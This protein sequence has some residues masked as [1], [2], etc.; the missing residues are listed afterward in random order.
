MNYSSA[1]R[2]PLGPT[3]NEVDTLGLSTPVPNAK[4]GP[5]LRHKSSL[6]ALNVHLDSSEDY[7]SPHSSIYN[8]SVVQHSIDKT[9]SWEECH[10]LMPTEGQH[11]PP[12]WENIVVDE[13]GVGVPVSFLQPPTT[14]KTHTPHELYPITEQSSFATLRPSGSFITRGRMSN[15]TL[16][17]R[18]PGLNGK[19]RKSFSL[20][21]LPPAFER[22]QSSQD[23]LPL[24]PLPRPVQP[25]QVP[26]ERIPTPPGLP[27][28]NKP[29]AINY[30]LPPPKFRWRHAFAVPSDAEMEWRRQTVGLPRGVVMRGSNG[31]LVRGK[32]TPIRSA[33]FPPLHQQRGALFHTPGPYAAEPAQQDQGVIPP[34][35]APT[36]HF[37]AGLRT[38]IGLR[39]HH[40][41]R[42]IET[43]KV[44]SKRKV[45][46]FFCCIRDEAAEPI[47][48]SQEDGR[49]GGR[50]DPRETPLF[51]G[52][53]R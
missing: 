43:K 18:S 44:K 12:P 47:L 9:G 38:R 36:E 51:V 21:D 40:R 3:T 50:A 26:P 15:S 49:Y 4:T 22:T 6:T 19:K 10:T 29:E 45:S 14:K 25:N 37:S 1:S 8:A 20:G 35:A 39:R 32:F 16:R 34:G 42:K 48:Y 31:V 17:S 28:F 24:P 2:H 11:E 23:S 53:F 41:E 30:R 27:S 13:N 52:G 33:H 5:L 46:S 7:P